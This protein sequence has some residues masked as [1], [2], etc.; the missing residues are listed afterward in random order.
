[1]AE[2]DFK[3]Y[4]TKAMELEV[5]IYTQKKLMA[6]HK[7]VIR[8]QH[9]VEP[10]KK[11]VAKPEAP[12]RRPNM[13]DTSSPGGFGFFVAMMILI[14]ILG[15][16]CLFSGKAIVVAL[17]CIV[18]GGIG[19]KVA[20]EMNQASKAH[21]AQ[22]AIIEQ[23]Y[24]AA[25]AKYPELLRLYEAEAAEA[26]KAY[27]EAMVAYN[28]EVVVYNSESA[29]VM[30]QHQATLASLEN[31]LEVLYD[32]NVIFPKY[33]NMVA[34]ITINEYLMSGRCFELEGP[35]GA[36]NLYE[37]E[38]RQNIIIGQLATVIDNL[39]QI[40]NN[41]FSLYRELVHTN[42]TVNQI[43][44]ELRDLRKTTKLSAY[45]A[46]ITAKIAASPKIIKGIIH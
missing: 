28:N 12:K 4:T 18:I 39:E 8:E 16:L 9:P 23:E 25:Q 37:M 46:G 34:I 24:Q 32:E 7:D 29:S 44:Y 17:I 14:G 30:E 31:A 40:R 41:Q 20:I 22:E 11:D 15:V 5:A 6:A 10:R 26:Q 42:D 3:A 1:M 36:Y 45:F 27:S 19:V 21:D 33:R 38:L 13:V 35:N 43:I 2:T